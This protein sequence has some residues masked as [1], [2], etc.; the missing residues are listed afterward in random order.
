MHP[1][2]AWR[3]HQHMAPSQTQR[4]LQLHTNSMSTRRAPS[5]PHTLP[6]PH[7]HHHRYID[8]LKQLADSYKDRPFAWLWVEGVQQPQLEANFDVGG[9]GYPA[10]IAFA[11]KDQ[12]FSTLKGAFQLSA[13]KEWV[14]AIRHGQVSVAKITGELAAVGS[15]NAWDG[16]D[17]QEVVEEEFSLDDIMG[18]DKDEL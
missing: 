17:G 5:L 16:S 6:R 1:S 10:V 9:F 13:T 12:R 4:T 3:H 14:E 2:L 11:P 8:I 7:H 15:V 18:D